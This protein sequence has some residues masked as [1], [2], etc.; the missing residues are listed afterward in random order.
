MKEKNVFKCARESES[1]NVCV[2][3][4]VHRAPHNLNVAFVCC[5]KPRWRYNCSNNSEQ[6]GNFAR[7]TACDMIKHYLRHN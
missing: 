2:F 1:V 5:F 6:A 4:C 7:G 3:L